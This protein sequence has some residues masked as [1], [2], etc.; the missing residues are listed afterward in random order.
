MF[1]LVLGFCV[2]WV[3]HLSYLLVIDRQARLLHRRLE[4]R[5]GAAPKGV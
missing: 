5:A 3:C 1:Y 2:V 4:A